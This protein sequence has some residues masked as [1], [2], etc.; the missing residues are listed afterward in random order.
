M[1][2][3]RERSIFNHGGIK[4]PIMMIDE[5]RNR[6]FSHA[7]V[8]TASRWKLDKTIPQFFYFFCYED[9]DQ[10]NDLKLKTSTSHDGQTRRSKKARA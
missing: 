3:I 5:F 6:S 4:M 7:D 1:L 10:R 8:F 9:G 2:S